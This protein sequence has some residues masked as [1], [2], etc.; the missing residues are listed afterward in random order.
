MIMLLAIALAIQYNTIILDKK[1]KE[2]IV[3]LEKLVSY[4]NKQA[5]A[6]F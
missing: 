1:K 4:P 5:Q 2:N 6:H 3:S